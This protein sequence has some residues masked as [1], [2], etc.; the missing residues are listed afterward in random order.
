MYTVLIF[1]DPDYNSSKDREK[2]T[3]QKENVLC[4]F[5]QED[6]CLTDCRHKTFTIQQFCAGRLII[7]VK[8]LSLKFQSMSPFLQMA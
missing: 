8:S 1:I 3:R 2:D 6:K 4:N 5:S 7:Y